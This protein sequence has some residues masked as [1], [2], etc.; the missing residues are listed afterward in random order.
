MVAADTW[1]AP[2]AVT[3]RTP[4][5]SLHGSYSHHHV[6]KDVTSTPDR[7]LVRLALCAPACAAAGRVLL[8]Q[9]YD[10]THASYSLQNVT[11]DVTNAPGR[12]L[13]QP[14]LCEPACA[15]ARLVRYC[16]IQPYFMNMLLTWP[17]SCAACTLRA[18]MC[19]SAAYLLLLYPTNISH[20]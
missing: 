5:N 9:P 11:K 20:H 19:S 4:N 12:A 2:A 17:C 15:A 6:T 18:S 16:C 14:A 10:P 13:V 3:C 8:S 1:C 7:A